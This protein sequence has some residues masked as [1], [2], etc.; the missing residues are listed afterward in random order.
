MKRSTMEKL[1]EASTILKE[2]M[3]LGFDLPSIE[4]ALEYAQERL[5]DDE[6]PS[7]VHRVGIIIDQLNV[8][9]LGV[10]VA[11]LFKPGNVDPDSLS[12]ELTGTYEQW[13]E[14]WMDEE[15]ERI[16]SQ[17]LIE[18]QALYEKVLK[19]SARA[20]HYTAHSIAEAELKC[21]LQRIKALTGQNVEPNEDGTLEY[22][23]D[24]DK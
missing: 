13:A 8:T 14:M 11:W 22:V 17:Y 16:A 2:A 23:E 19:Y 10:L 12:S 20:F 4:K 24:K 9:D 18:A 1:R 6:L 21:K 5:T 3:D 7:I 15:S